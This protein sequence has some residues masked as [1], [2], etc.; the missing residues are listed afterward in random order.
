[1]R[2]TE[3]ITGT[4]LGLLLYIYVL[5]TLILS[6]PGVMV[7]LAKQDAWLSVFPSALTGLLTIWVMITLANR[8]PG[9]T[10]IQY[11]SKIIG[12]WPGKC[13][14][15]YLSYYWFSFIGV[16]LY[17][18][19][20]YVHTF[21]LP[22][23]PIWVGTLT[24]LILSGLA[25]F[26]GIEVIGRCNEFLTPIIIAFLIPLFILA[27]GDSDPGQLKPVL[28]EGIVP[29][30]K[31]AF[32]PSGFMSQF[33]LLGWFLP[34]LNQPKKALKISLISLLG[35]VLFLFVINLL[36]IMVLG[37][38]TGKLNYAFSSL[39]QYIGVQ[40]SFERLEAFTVTI[41]VMGLFVK[42]SVTLFMLCYSLSQL[43]GIRSYRDIIAPV[44]LLS[45]VGSVWIFKNSAEYQS[46]ISIYSFN[47]FFT[48]NLLPLA[49]LLIDSLK[50]SVNKSL[51]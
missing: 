9:L 12:K 49:L 15:V 50:R 38:I 28:A 47:A 33:F 39:I 6:V 19:A 10:I 17:G 3:K 18:H 40:G 31:G 36:T 23:T 43:F 32:V 26:A 34:F 27:I 29:V 22:I 11:S 14:G 48:Q 51:L 8:Y 16:L 37:P 21:L 25:V 2:D 5:S 46:Y 35:I 42:L 44:T 13:L 7:K 24:I 20:G 30:L 45:M 4:Q 41:W 1:M